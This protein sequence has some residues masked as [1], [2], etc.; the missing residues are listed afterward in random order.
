MTSRWVRVLGS[1]LLLATTTA[2][3]ADLQVVTVHATEAGFNGPERIPS[4]LTAFD[5]V[6][7]GW[8]PHR[9]VLLRLGEG[10]T[11][12]SLDAISLD[13]A[14][15]AGVEALGGSDVHR[16][17]GAG[18]TIIALEPGRHALLCDLVE[19]GQHAGKAWIQPLEVL[20]YNEGRLPQGAPVI[21]L[22]ESGM[23]APDVLASGEQRL[24]VENQAPRARGIVVFR[25]RHG[26]SHAEG[27]AWL[28]SGT[29]R[30]PL[31]RV[32]GAAP[33]SNG[34]ALLLPATLN[35]GEYLLYA[36]GAGAPAIRPLRVVSER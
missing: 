21:T 8:K 31:V 19:E 14:L 15:P 18:R 36:T 20:A 35:H 32:L 33:L 11:L 9:M 3:A 23:A 27:A 28:Q 25:L 4:G 5:F 6:N 2:H 22:L 12:E 17:E 30:S 24:R 16:A 13:A 26:R 10:T 1:L 7:K 34:R 29:G